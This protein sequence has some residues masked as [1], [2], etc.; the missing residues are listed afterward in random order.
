[1]VAEDQRVGGGRLMRLS[2]LWIDGWHN[3]RDVTI[4]F[5]VRRLTTVVIGQNGVGKSNL[6]EAIAYIFRNADLGDNPPPFSFDLEYR[7]NTF[8][9]QI[10]GKLNEWNFAVDKSSISRSEFE[11]RKGELFPDLVFGYYSGGNNRLE[12]IFN[13]HQKNYYSKIIRENPEGDDQHVTIDD[14]RLFYC[15]PIH[16]VLALLCFFGFPEPD[17][18]RLLEDMLGITGFHSSMVLFRQPWFA[19]SA[20]GRPKGL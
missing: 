2:R 20:R 3:L 19:K 17:I 18:H 16:G 15:R 1:M 12:S 9:V 4:D 11:R 10:T 5:D 8:T 6:L 7:I 13:T 14:R